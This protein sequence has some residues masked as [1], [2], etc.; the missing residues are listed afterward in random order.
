MAEELR[1][2]FIQGDSVFR[3]NHQ[4]FSDAEV[5]AMLQGYIENCRRNSQWILDTR[6][7]GNTLVVEHLFPAEEFIEANS[8]RMDIDEAFVESLPLTYP[9]VFEIRSGYLRVHKPLAN[10]YGALLSDFIRGLWEVLLQGQV[11]CLWDHGFAQCGG[12]GTIQLNA[13]GLLEP[14]EPIIGF[15]RVD[16]DMQHEAWAYITPQGLI[17]VFDDDDVLAFDKVDMRNPSVPT[18]VFSFSMIKVE[19]VGA[20]GGQTVKTALS[21]KDLGELDQARA[22]IRTM[23]SSPHQGRPR[24]MVDPNPLPWLMVEG[25][26][27]GYMAQADLERY[28]R[29]HRDAG[30]NPFGDGPRN[31]QEAMGNPFAESWEE[32]PSRDDNPFA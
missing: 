6:E 12:V 24:R 8:D 5:Q 26:E 15:Y 17:L 11:K 25:E 32:N 9:I 30:R 27:L 13:Y 14:D 10:K 31:V 23:L 1:M 16:V 2:R 29:R 18:G 19:V 21:P 3:L 28:R 4:Q 7:E 22:D 20:G